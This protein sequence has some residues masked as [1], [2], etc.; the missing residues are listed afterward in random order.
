MAHRILLTGASG[1]L[2]GT[3]LARWKS[4]GLPP[5]E[6]LYAL[7][8]MEEQA[9]AVKRY[10]AEPLTFSLK[11]EAATREAIISN[12]I[13]I[14]LFL[15]DAFY[16]DSQVILIKALAEVKK[17]TGNDVHFLHVSGI[18]MLQHRRADHPQR[19]AVPKYFPAMPAHRQIDRFMTMTRNCMKSRRH[20]KHRCRPFSR[21]D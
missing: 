16:S 20:R 15:V 4:A 3:L 8:R 18:E 6:Q 1:Y 14:V 9:Q 11:D 12:K 2:G 13:D 21:Y 10:G 17:L 5:Y 7:V 19:L